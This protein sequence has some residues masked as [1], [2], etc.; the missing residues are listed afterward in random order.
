MEQKP[1]IENCSVVLRVS[2]RE[3]G[4]SKMGLY[5]LYEDVS[6]KAFQQQVIQVARLTG[7]LAYH[8]LHSIG[9]EPGFPDLVLVHPLRPSL[10]MPELKSERGRLTRAQERWL[11]A[12]RANGVEAPVWRPHDIDEILER[13]K[14]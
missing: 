14:R 5:R 2:G 13:L 11:A 9:S 7:H 4:M 1:C 8:T 6:E 12:L 10:L 3:A